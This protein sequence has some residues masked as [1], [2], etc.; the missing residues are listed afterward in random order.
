M[1]K[2][3]TFVFIAIITSSLFWGCA[4]KSEK[5]KEISED[6]IVSLSIS[7]NKYETDY[8]PLETRVEKADDIV[9]GEVKAVDYTSIGGG[10][11]WTIETFIVD[12][13][14]KGNLSAGDEIIVYEAKGYISIADY[15][16][17]L[18]DGDE[19]LKTSLRKQYESLSDE[20]LSNRYIAQSDGTPFSKLGDKNVLF[21]VESDY[22]S[23]K[24]DNTVF[25]MLGG[26]F[27]RY[28]QMD[29]G[30]L[31]WIQPDVEADISMLR[32]NMII[33]EYENAGISLEQ[34]KHNI[35]DVEQ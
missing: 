12:E 26:W 34:L 7:E 16:E 32:S 35:K 15:I 20:E 31:V 11:A 13:V 3:M 18:S 5:N 28:T 4:S 17:K 30:D 23:D 25:E 9:Y 14:L 29:D 6:E 24:N 1:N 10:I 2:K 8:H 33:K 21:I 27:G 22:W 19:V